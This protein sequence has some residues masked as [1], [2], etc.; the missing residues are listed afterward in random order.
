[1]NECAVPCRSCGRAGLQLVLSLGRTPLAN[2]L[3][4]AEQLRQPEPTYPLEVAF[5]PDCSLLQITETVP[6]E[7]LFREYYYFSSFSD[8]MLAHARQLAEE[9]ISRRRLNGSSLVME[10]AS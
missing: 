1:M 3:L 10:V 5:C 4:S 8:A 9:M 6:P 7:K 2:A